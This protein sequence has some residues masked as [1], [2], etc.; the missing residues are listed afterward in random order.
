MYNKITDKD[1]EYLRTIVPAEDFFC[2]DEISKDFA[3]DELGTVAHMPDVLMYV[4]SAEEVSKIMK[5]ANEHLIPVVARGSGTGL[6]G[7]CV[8]LEGGIIINTTKM[9][10][11]LELDENNLTLTVEPGVLLMEIYDYV[12]PKGFFYAPDPGEKSATIGG[13]ISTNAGG[14]RAVKWGVTR[15]W[16]RAIEVVLP[17]GEIEHFGR[18][19]VKDSTGYSLKN[20]ICFF[21]EKSLNLKHQLGSPT[22]PGQLILALSSNLSKSCN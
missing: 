22:V 9:N 7:A 12:E 13:N 6:V 20:L 15:D 21:Q 18:K 8:P 16:V 17:T 5:Y 14:M 1:L 3:K 19:V 2:G 11:I 10:N 4:K